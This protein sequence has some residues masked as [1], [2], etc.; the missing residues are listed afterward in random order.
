MDKEKVFEE[1]YLLLKGLVNFAGSGAKLSR[2]D[3]E[4][5]LQELALVLWSCIEKFDGRASFSTYFYGRI[6]GAF[7]NFL[8]RRLGSCGDVCSLDGLMDDGFNEEEVDEKV[9][10]LS[11]L[12]VLN[13][14]EKVVVMLRNFEGRSFREI[15]ENLHISS[16]R[17]Y[18]IYRKALKKLQEGGVK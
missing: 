14:R 11:S 5:L 17:A 6:R 7:L 15:G 1:Y 13:D 12:K 10:L 9:D 2:E 3:K 16:A 4:D 8:K 18:Q